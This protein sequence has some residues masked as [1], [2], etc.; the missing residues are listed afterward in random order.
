MSRESLNIRNDTLSGTGELDMPN[1]QMICSL[2]LNEVI[3][4]S[5]LLCLAHGIQL[6]V[7]ICVWPVQRRGRRSNGIKTTRADIF[8]LCHDRSIRC[9][10]YM[11]FACY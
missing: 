11:G 7:N 9:V 5:Q 2:P 3:D 4:E 6:V 8:H 1:G 10:W